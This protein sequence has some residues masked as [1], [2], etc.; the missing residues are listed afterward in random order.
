MSTA[1]RDSLC[2]HDNRSLSPLAWKDVRASW[3]APWDEFT[4]VSLR[5]QS[6]PGLQASSNLQLKRK[7]G[8]KDEQQSIPCVSRS[9]ITC[10]LDW[11]VSLG[12]II[13]VDISSPAIDARVISRALCP[14]PRSIIH[15]VHGDFKSERMASYPHFTSLTVMTRQ[16]TGQ[17]TKVIACE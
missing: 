2:R 6:Q 4:G 11:S 13:T 17:Q 7:G 8:A 15:P 10:S 16:S 14:W 12:R 1:S 5:Q 9:S 3:S